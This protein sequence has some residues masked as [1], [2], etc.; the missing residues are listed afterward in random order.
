VIC[1]TTEGK[2]FFAQDWTGQISLESL[3]K[4][5]WCDTRLVTANEGRDGVHAGKFGRGDVN[6]PTRS[7]VTRVIKYNFLSVLVPPI[8]KCEARRRLPVVSKFSD[9][10][11][12]DKDMQNLDFSGVGARSDAVIPG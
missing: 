11:C 1:P 6:D 10:D 5:P 9:G 8:A 4:S 7:R 12:Y 3:R 2:C